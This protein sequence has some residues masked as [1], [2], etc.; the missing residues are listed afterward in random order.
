[1][2]GFFHV[3]KEWCTAQAAEYAA[4]YTVA[5]LPPGDASSQRSMVARARPVTGHASSSASPLSF[6]W[7]SPRHACGQQPALVGIHLGAVCHLPAG[8]LHPK[9]G[10]EAPQASRHLQEL[11][12]QQEVANV[13]GLTAGRQLSPRVGCSGELQ[14]R[15]RVPDAV[16][17][18]VPS[19]RGRTGSRRNVAPQ[20]ARVVK[21][22]G[23]MALRELIIEC[24]QGSPVRSAYARDVV[25]CGVCSFLV[26]LDAAPRIQSRAFLISYASI[27]IVYTLR[28]MSSPWARTGSV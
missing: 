15:P 13:S 5:T 9:T 6:F 26:L 23:W 3:S 28:M 16:E 22:K 7:P 21:S 19:R 17:I 8:G 12:V 10:A 27:I 4:L 24:G 25:A 1:M 20:S 14:G 2:A 11:T 18:K